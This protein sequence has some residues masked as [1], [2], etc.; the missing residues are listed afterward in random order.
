MIVEIWAM[1]IYWYAVDESEYFFKEIESSL[2]SDPL[3]RA[4]EY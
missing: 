1:K 2:I 3:I 4:P